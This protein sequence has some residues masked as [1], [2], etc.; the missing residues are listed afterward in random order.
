MQR[1]DRGA[2]IGTDAEMTGWGDGP[3]RYPDIST[4]HPQTPET[5]YETANPNH[6][7]PDEGSEFAVKTCQQRQSSG[8]QCH[9]PALPELLGTRHQLYSSCDNVTGGPLPSSLQSQRHC[10]SKAAEEQ[11]TSSVNADPEPAAWLQRVKCSRTQSGQL[12]GGRAV[13]SQG[14]KVEPTYFR[15]AP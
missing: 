1:Q 9:R 10:D 7:V 13:P 12:P 11:K 2:G 4:L 15:P 3:G 8:L 14:R 5:Q 6:P